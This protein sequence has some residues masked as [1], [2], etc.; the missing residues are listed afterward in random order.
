MQSITACVMLIY[1]AKV[2]AS[3]C[4]GVVREL[5]ERRVVHALTSLVVKHEKDGKEQHVTWWW[6]WWWWW[7]W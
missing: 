6:W 7:W 5:V 3:T 1:V 2:I 4:D